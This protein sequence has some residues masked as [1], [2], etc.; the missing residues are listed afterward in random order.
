MVDGLHAT[1]DSIVF[2]SEAIED[3]APGSRVR[4]TDGSSAAVAEGRLTA[5]GLGDHM[6]RRTH[7]PEGSDHLP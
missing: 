5:F 3:I 1:P 7:G 2:R 4:E 6:L